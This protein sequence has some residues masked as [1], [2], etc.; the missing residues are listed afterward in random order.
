MEC[1]FICIS[2]V[3]LKEIQALF[4][5]DDRNISGIFDPLKYRFALLA[6]PS[7]FSDTHIRWRTVDGLAPSRLGMITYAETA[8]RRSWHVEEA[9]SD[10]TALEIRTVLFQGIW[11][12]SPHC[13][14]KLARCNLICDCTSRTQDST[15]NVD[16]RFI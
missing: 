11:N 16:W 15:Y 1:A 2:I 7:H 8:D 4:W 12:N 10:N 6:Y 13:W 3:I 14:S 5:Y 9:V